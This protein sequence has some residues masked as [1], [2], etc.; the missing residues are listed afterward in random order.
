MIHKKFDVGDKIFAKVRGYPPWP[1]RVEGVAEETPNKIKYHVFFYGTNETAVCKSIELFPYLEFRAK[2]GKRCKKKGFNEALDLVDL[3]LGLDPYDGN[4]TNEKEGSNENSDLEGSLV[5]N[6]TSSGTSLKKLKSAGDTPVIKSIAGKRKL[7]DNGDIEPSKENEGITEKQNTSLE[8]TPETK[9]PDV[10]RSGR[11]IK[12]KKFADQND[13]NNYNHEESEISS[14]KASRSSIKSKTNK[15]L[16]NRNTSDIPL[17]NEMLK[18]DSK[19]DENEVDPDPEFLN[20]GVLLVKTGNKEYLFKFDLNVNQPNLKNEEVKEQWE[21]NVL[22]D[23]QRTK[24]YIESQGNLPESFLKEMVEKYNIKFETKEIKVISNDKEK[25]LTYLKTEAQLLDLDQK[26]RSSL[27]LREANPENCLASL[28]QI[29]EL[30]LTPQMLNKY[31]HVVETFKKLRKYVG[32]TSTW[33]MT[34]IELQIFES[35]AKNIRLKAE[36][37]MNKI[38]GLFL[39]AYEK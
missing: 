32:N 33:N 13:E 35:K 12:Y 30:K 5:I 14:S 22:Q 17:D 15:E 9:W 20:N 4:Q 7:E 29:L 10:T 18:N 1:A 23:K 39:T 3:E 28:D 19:V 16:N 27:T 36:Y 6:E 2:M 25:K 8:G 24:N 34:P 21:K 38:R 26:I 37:V 31:P 11:K